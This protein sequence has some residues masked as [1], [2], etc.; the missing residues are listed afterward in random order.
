LDDA[1]PEEEGDGFKLKL[2][3]TADNGEED[4][5]FLKNDMLEDSGA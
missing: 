4:D 2:L 1:N 5:E 3:H